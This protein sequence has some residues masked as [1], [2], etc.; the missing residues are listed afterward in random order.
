[1]APVSLIHGGGR[2]GGGLLLQWVQ[3]TFE[4]HTH[5]HTHT[6]TAI[7]SDI[8]RSHCVCEG[9]AGAVMGPGVDV[10][11]RVTDM[12]VA[13]TICY[14]GGSRSPSAALVLVPVYPSV[15]LRT[16]FPLCHRLL[17]PRSPTD[18]LLSLLVQ[19]GTEKKNVYISAIV[20]THVCIVKKMMHNVHVQSFIRWFKGH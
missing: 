7:H 13:V 10:A 14:L 1:M 12:P 18:Q 20:Q 16:V 4:T 19:Q 6:H 8:Q 15:H 11:D 5:T 9:E 2:G 3:G 17:L